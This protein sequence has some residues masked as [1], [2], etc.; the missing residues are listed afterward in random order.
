M[1]ALRGI[2][3][4]LLV[5]LVAYLLSNNKRGIRWRPILGGLIIQVTLAFVVLRWEMGKEGLLAVKDAVQQVINASQ[6]GILFMFGPL[7]S[8]EVMGEVFGNHMAFVFAFRVLPLIIFFASLI[9]VL[10]YIGVMQILVNFIGGGLQ[11]ILGTSR[12]ES[13]AAAANIFVGQSE[14]PLVIRPYLEKLS[15]SGLFAVVVG[16]LASVAG[17]M[18]GG[19]AALGVPLEYLLAACFMS[20]P[21]GLVM[22]KLIYPENKEIDDESD[23]DIDPCQIN[24]DTANIV[25]AAAKGAADGLMMALNIGAMLMAFISLIA[26]GNLILGSLQNESAIIQTLVLIVGIG[27]IAF[28]IYLVRRQNL[29]TALPALSIGSTLFVMAASAIVGGVTLEQVFGWVFSPLAWVIGVPWEEIQAGGSFIGQ[30]LVLNEF[31][32]YASLVGEMNNLSPKTTLVISFALC[33]FANFGSM[34]INLG[35][36]AKLAPNRRAEVARILPKAVAGGML[37]SCLSASLAGMFFMG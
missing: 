32:A 35:T 12:P 19:Y 36:Y 25:D 15:P 24:G 22:A 26:L 7:A 28:G 20:A 17:S 5:L 4:I 3:G 6:Q 31:V 27:T 13:M 30:K 16:G 8:N 21:A 23:M 29:K 18:L 34:A 10:Y 33:G 14:A 1:H 9:S 37:A 11:K 2:I